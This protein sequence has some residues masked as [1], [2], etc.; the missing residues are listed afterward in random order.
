MKN[1]DMKRFVRTAVW[2]FRMERM[3]M[4]SV[5]CGLVA[6]FFFTMFFQIWPVLKGAGGMDYDGYIEMLLGCSLVYV[7]YIVIGG[8]FI[9]NNMNT[10]ENRT[11]FMML[12]S[13]DLEKYLVRFLYASLGWVVMS[14]TA[15]C[16]ADMLR[17]AVC[18]VGGADYVKCAV[19]DFV[20]ILATGYDTAG[21]YV[22]GALKSRAAW[23]AAIGWAMWSHSFFLLGGTIFRRSPLVFSAAFYL[24][25]LLLFVTVNVG[26]SKSFNLNIS[27][28]GSDAML[29]TM[30]VLFL[31]CAAFDWWLGYKLFRRMQVI[32]YKWI[33]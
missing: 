18:A 33:N 5:S 14:M 31:G 11:A 20:G 1:F 19:P 21:N 3:N 22:A 16:V 26:T 30:S 28:D 8:A 12:P 13:T 9:F 27:I 2:M 23:F 6:G 15:F 10:K 4:L 32:T 25:W 17:I 7:I 29:Y 24:L